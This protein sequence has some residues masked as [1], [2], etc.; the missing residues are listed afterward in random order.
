V[1]WE[2]LEHTYVAFV[3]LACGLLCFQ[4]SDRVK[5]CLVSE[6]VLRPVAHMV[7]RRGEVAHGRACAGRV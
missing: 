4:A 3:Q 1:R 5:V 2:N 6:W 7:R